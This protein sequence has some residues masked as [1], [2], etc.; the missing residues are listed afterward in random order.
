MTFT[1]SSAMA[2]HTAQVCPPS[3]EPWRAGH[4][5]CQLNGL[6]KAGGV[7]LSPPRRFPGVCTVIAPQTSPGQKGPRSGATSLFPG[8][9]PGYHSTPLPHQGPSPCQG[10]DTLLLPVTGGRGPQDSR[11]LSKSHQR[12]F[13][14]GKKLP[15]HSDTMVRKVQRVSATKRSSHR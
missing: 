14:K 11:L 5:H 7:C 12:P 15:E 1:F 6:P 13:W 9:S 2:I 4:A 10:P 3:S 8:V